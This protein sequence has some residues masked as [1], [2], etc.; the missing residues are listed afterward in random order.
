[1][2][3]YHQLSLEERERLSMLKATGMSLRDI[4][5]KLNRSHTSLSRELRRN[6]TG[7]GKKSRELL[8]FQYI[9]HRAQ[10]KADKRGA[11]QR[12]HAPLKEPFIFLYVREHLRKPYYWSPEEIANRL[13]MDHPGY[14][15]DDETI[16]RYIY[17]KKTRGMTLW[18]HLKHHRKRR[19]KH[20]GRKVQQGRLPTALKIEERP[21]KANTRSEEGHWETDNAGTIKTDKTGISVSVERKLRVV[22][23]RKLQDLT[24]G[25]KR[26]VLV[27]QLKQEKQAL[28]KTMTIDRGP[29]NSQ[30]EQFTTETQM[31]VYACNPYHSWEKGSVENTIGRF[32]RF[33]PKGSSV[34]HL[35]QRQLTV[36]EKR[37]NNTPRKCLGYLTPNEMLEKIHTGSHT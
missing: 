8:T 36:I 18:Q 25:T 16:Y 35:T 22:R 21:E 5:K 26:S 30:H 33:V 3:T 23:L 32:R 4:A 20:H 28:Q 37:M 2:R 7:Q 31:P 27:A 15:I 17:G 6:R 10:K 24:A 11:K 12:Y 9:P 34:D 29:E 14:T 1:M 13:P 19:M